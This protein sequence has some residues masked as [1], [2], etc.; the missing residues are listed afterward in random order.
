MKTN[1]ICCAG[2]GGQGVM[3]MGKLLAYAGMLEGKEVSWCPSYGPEMR[4]GTANCAVVVSDSPVGSP[5]VDSNATAAVVM[6]LP[7]FEKFVKVVGAGG[8]VI[9]NSSLIEEEVKRTDV[10]VYKIPVNE[11]ANELGNPKLINIIML[12]ALIEI[13]KTV[14]PESIIEA[15]KKVFG[16]SKEKFVPINREALSKGAQIIKEYD[17]M[18]LK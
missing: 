13:E 16:P 4:G 3:S 7:S 10:R 17:K 15:F 1:R 5:I 14:S 6:N 11:I 18:A 12:G 8:T 9:I 2:F